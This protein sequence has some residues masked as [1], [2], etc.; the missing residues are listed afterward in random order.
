[1][2]SFTLKKT[3]YI[4]ATTVILFMMF[5]GCMTY[6]GSVDKTVPIS[7]TTMFKLPERLQVVEFNGKPVNWQ[8][9]MGGDFVMAI[10]AGRNTLTF[11]YTVITGTTTSSTVVPRYSATGGLAGFSTI[12]I[13][14]PTTQ[15]VRGIK[16]QETFKAGSTYM[17]W[18]EHLPDNKVKVNIT[19]VEDDSKDFLLAPAFVVPKEQHITAK[20]G[21]YIM[22]LGASSTAYGMYYGYT[23][24]RVYETD[25]RRTA[26]NIEFGSNFGLYPHTIVGMD[27]CLGANYEYYFDRSGKGG[28][29]IGGGLI[30]PFLMYF[31]ETAP[32]MHPYIRVGMPYVF[33][34]GMKVGFHVSY[35]F[36]DLFPDSKVKKIYSD[37]SYYNEKSPDWTMSRFGFG[38]FIAF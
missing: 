30:S 17:A 34:N 28:I 25:T 13:A 14:V 5:T 11:N 20:E 2:R 9:S 38:V 35:F 19:L 8:N 21:K 6:K 1:M 10:P 26:W 12:P 31:M 4:A 22:G 27:L 16:V 7:K 3:I 24:G 15:I 18:V 33:D 29:S 36:R 37:E 23:Y 32:I